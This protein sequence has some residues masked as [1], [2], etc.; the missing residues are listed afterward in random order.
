MA[1]RKPRNVFEE[2]DLE[3]GGEYGELEGTFPPSFVRAIKSS[4]TA[5]KANCRQCGASMNPVDAMVG[6][7]PGGKDIK[8]PI[9]GKCARENQ[10]RVTG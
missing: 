2:A 10:R 9:C 1:K 4:T 3:S 7:G 6:S 5:H 8:T